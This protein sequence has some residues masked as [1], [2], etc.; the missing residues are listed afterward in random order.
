[1]GEGS[2]EETLTCCL[3]GDW[4]QPEK[5]SLTEM[6]LKMDALNNAVHIYDDDMSDESYKEMKCLE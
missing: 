4:G 3:V 5:G 2:D 1:M 6:P